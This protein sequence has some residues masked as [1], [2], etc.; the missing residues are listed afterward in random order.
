LASDWSVSGQCYETCIC[1]FVCPCVPGQLAVMATKQSCTFAMAFQI[2]EIGKGNRSV[3][4]VIDERATSDQH[5]AIA[6]IA[7]GSAGGPMAA[8]SGLVGKFL[9]V[10][11]PDSV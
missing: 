8:L 4:L 7:S 1:D 10:E 2:E 3:G 11:R 6:A 9:G 5:E